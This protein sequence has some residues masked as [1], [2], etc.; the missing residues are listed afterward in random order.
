MLGHCWQSKHLSKFIYHHLRTQTAFY[1]EGTK[2]NVQ[3]QFDLRYV[4]YNMNG[5]RKYILTSV[6]AVS[7]Y[8]VAKALKTKKASQIP[9]ESNI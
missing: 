3:H 7:G 4:L 8:K 1:L 5:T 2:P 6:D 9:F